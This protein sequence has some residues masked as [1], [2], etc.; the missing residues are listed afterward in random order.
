MSKERIYLYDTTLRDG[1]QTLGVL[2][3]LEDKLKLTREL[4]DIGIDYIE[5]GFTGANE[6]DRQYFENLPKTRD[7][8]I[9]AFGMTKRADHSADNDVNLASLVNSN[10]KTVC[11]V[12]K[13]HV[14]HVQKALGIT[15][16]QNFDNIRQSIK[17][18]VAK[19]K[20]V[21]FDAEHFFDGYF[22]DEKYALDCVKEAYLAG[23][24]WVVLCDT[25]GGTLPKDIGTATKAV[26]EYG[27]PGDR[28]GIHTHNDT[29]NAVAGSLAAIDAGARHIQ[30]TINGIGERC[31]N[32]NL[33]TIIGNLRLKEPYRSLYDTGVT[34]EKLQKLTHLSR[35]LDDIL[36]RIPSKN[37]AYVGTSA[38]A[39]K[40]GLHGSGVLR[41]P[42]TYEHVDPEDVG[43]K[44]VIPLSNQAGRSHL[45]SWLKELGV[46]LKTVDDDTLRR[47]VD[48]IKLREDKGYTY[49]VAPESCQLLVKR[50]LGTLSNYFT[51]QRFRVN[52]ESHHFNDNISKSESEAVVVIKIG[53]ERKISVS[54][55]LT[56]NLDS[57]PVHA[58]S[59][60]LQRDLGP[61]QKYI[62]DMKLVDFKVRIRG[63]G[64]SAVTRVVI[65]CTNSD[66]LTWAT[67][68]VSPNIIEASFE[69]LVEAIIWKLDY[70]QA[71]TAEQLLANNFSL[72]DELIESKSS[73]KPKKDTFLTPVS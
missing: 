51:V 67:A 54:E 35:L 49:D 25:N 42:A 8:Q 9:T 19:G 71:P 12:G 68:G 40:A 14:F 7:A 70:D 44:R 72:I 20:E 13:T 38:F 32:A 57:G 24:R 1:A 65:E 21:I 73:T 30:G 11:I 39:H 29:E 18:L 63:A 66:G 26:I 45:R 16:E 5:G 52:V 15:L 58:L 69:A 17:H 3:G 43:N 6:T 37:A 34:L 50:M 22:S 48:E 41:E 64:T 10:T 61:Y 59:K 53:N 27:I 36:D 46:D 28:L 56:D 31:G 62:S 47:I 4:D 33:I 55:G 60:A 23:A 2:F